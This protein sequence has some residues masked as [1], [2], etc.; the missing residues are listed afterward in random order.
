M[1]GSRDTKFARRSCTVYAVQVVTSEEW[2]RRA[3]AAGKTAAV[4][5][6]TEVC[7]RKG[8]TCLHVGVSLK[9]SEILEVG[10]RVTLND[11]GAGADRQDGR[12]KN[13]LRRYERNK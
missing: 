9:R 8:D 11:C 7:S 10:R 12:A 6:E 1:V 13:A 2:K 5:I 4:V 3:G